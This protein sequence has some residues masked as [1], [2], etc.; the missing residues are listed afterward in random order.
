MAPCCAMDVRM[1]SSSAMFLS[2]RAASSRSAVGSLMSPSIVTSCRARPSCSAHCR[3]SSVAVKL[4][5]HCTPARSASS[6][7]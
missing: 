6:R 3:N 1:S 7:W 5:R 4:D 2:E